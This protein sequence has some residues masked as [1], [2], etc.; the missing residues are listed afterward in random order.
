M[1]HLS[2]RNTQSHLVQVGLTGQVSSGRCEHDNKDKTEATGELGTR[3]LGQ[4]SWGRTAG[5]GAAGTG[6][7]GKAVSTAGTGQ[8]GHNTRNN[9]PETGQPGKES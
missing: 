7:K 5:T 4:D 1:L 3:V 9:R 8:P 6:Q 2:F